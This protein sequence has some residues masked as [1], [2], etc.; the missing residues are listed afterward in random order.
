MSDVSGDLSDH[1]EYA[2]YNAVSHKERAEE[3]KSDEY[4]AA[5]V[6]DLL[7]AYAYTSAIPVLKSADFDDVDEETLEVE[8]ELTADHYNRRATGNLKSAERLLMRM[9]SLEYNSGVESFGTSRAMDDQTE[10]ERAYHHA[11]V[12]EEFLNATDTIYEKFN[13]I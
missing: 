4:L 6:V 5:A 3:R 8:Q 12:T 2:Q 7:Y 1:V 11:I 9:A 10:A 13:L